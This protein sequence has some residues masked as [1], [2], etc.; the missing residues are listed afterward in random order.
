MSGAN[1]SPQLPSFPYSACRDGVQT[2]FIRL[3]AKLPAKDWLNRMSNNEVQALA[4]YL[5][6]GAIGPLGT[7]PKDT[8]AKW[9]SSNDFTSADFQNEVVF[10]NPNELGLGR[11]VNCKRRLNHEACYVTKYGHIGGSPF[12]AFDDTIHNFHPGDTVAME[13]DR[14]PS[15]PSVVKFYVYKPNGKLSTSTVFDTSGP[16][17]VPG[18]CKHCHGHNEFVVIEPHAYQYPG[19]SKDSPHGL[20]KQQEKFRLMNEAVAYAHQGKANDP[21]LELVHSLYLQGFETPGSKA[22]R[23]PPPFAWREHAFI[24]EHVIKPS[25]RT[26]HMWQSHSFDFSDPRDLGVVHIQRV[27]QTGMMP[28]AMSPM[29]RLWKTT[30]P[31]LMQA[32]EDSCLPNSVFGCGLHD[33]LTVVAPSSG[34]VTNSANGIVH[35]V[36]VSDVQDPQ[37]CCKVV[38]S[39]DKDGFLGTGKE[40]VHTYSTAGPRYISVVATDSAGHIGAKLFQLFVTSAPPKIKVVAPSGPVGYGG[41]NTVTHKATVTDIEDP[42][43][44]CHV[45]WKSDKDGQLGVGKEIE[46]VYSSPGRRFITVSATDSDGQTAH[47]TFPLDVTN[48][49]PGVAIEVPAAGTTIFR[50][51]AFVVQGRAADPNEIGLP[52]TKLTWTSSKPGDTSFPFTGC[53]RAVSFP[54]LGKRTL[55]LKGIDSH[56]ATATATRQV[57]VQAIPAGSKPVVTIVDPHDGDLLDPSPAIAL[58]SSVNAGA[59]AV[60]Y[61]WTVDPFGTE[62]DIGSDATLSWVPQSNVPFRCGGHSVVLKLYATNANGTGTASINIRVLYPVC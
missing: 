35:K 15:K 3:A 20:E 4:Y 43:K 31:N 49:P 30:R 22:R 7:G 5:S 10:Y 11:K 39:S 55:T 37:K 17:F 56:G 13:A 60:T 44:C 61:R 28:N 48:A 45:V 59:G 14:A 38:W 19:V 41:F 46:F 40:L 16:K 58:N 25:C 32:L 9:L 12:E 18:V 47:S 26:C 52:C 50:N 8:F 54:T 2:G 57:T 24:Y 1:V 34:L 29:L 42:Q 27:V 33:K 36:T 53:E 51:T 21:Y 6:I 23:A 62:V